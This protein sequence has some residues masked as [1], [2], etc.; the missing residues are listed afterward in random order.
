MSQDMLFLFK[1]LSQTTMNP[2]HIKC[3]MLLCQISSRGQPTLTINITLSPQDCN[4]LLKLNRGFVANCG[5][6]I[7]STRIIWTCSCMSYITLPQ[8]P[9]D[10]WLFKM[11]ETRVSLHTNV[12]LG[13]QMLMEMHLHEIYSGWRCI[14]MCVLAM[15]ATLQ[16]TV[17]CWDYWTKLASN[18]AM[19][20][21]VCMW[22]IQK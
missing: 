3:Q 17:H 15:H 21:A 4:G 11:K 14:S 20:Q 19:T 5:I 13:S 22:L 6:D 9:S 12:I 7:S 16:L 8:P 18:C 2:N 10:F 1:H